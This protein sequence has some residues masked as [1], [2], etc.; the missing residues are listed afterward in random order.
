MKKLSLALCTA[1]VVFAAST[2]ASA[3]FQV[4]RW[5]SGH[6]ETWNYALP[7]RP[8]LADY[9]VLTR[10]IPTFE[11]ALRAKQDLIAKRVCLF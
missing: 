6:C 11:L 8:M 9:K 1:A 2:P 3:Y 5:T 7:T 4:I 10:P